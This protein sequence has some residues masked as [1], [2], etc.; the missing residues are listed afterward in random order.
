MRTVPADFLEPHFNSTKTP[1]QVVEVDFGASDYVYFTSHSTVPTPDGF[2]V[3]PKGVK[4]VSGTSQKID[5]SVGRSTIGNIKVDLLDISDAL[6]TILK[7]RDDAGRG[8]RHKRVRAYQGFENMTWAQ[9]STNLIQTQIITGLSEHKGNYVFSCS[10]IQRTARDKIFSKA[11]ARLS[12]SI[13]STQLLIPVLTTDGFEICW[14]GSSYTDAPDTYVGYGLIDDEVIRYTGTTVDGSLGLCFVADQRGALNTAPA[15][16]EVDPEDTSDRA[17]YFE[18]FVYLELPAPKLIYA[19]LTGVLYGDGEV[20]PSNWHLNISEDFVYAQ[21]YLDAGDDLWLSDE[22]EGFIL[23]F[24]GEK[25][26]DGKKFIEQQICLLISAFLPVYSTGELGFK[27]ATSVLHRAPYVFELNE[28]S[29]KEFS[30][31]TFDTKAVH[32]LLTVKWNY[33]FLRDELTRQRIINDDLS[34]A[35]YGSAPALELSF[36]GLHGSRHTSAAVEALFD[37]LRDRFAAPPITMTL[38]CMPYTN[39]LEVGDIVRVN[40][41]GTKDYFD[42]GKIDRAM[43]IQSVSVDWTSGDVSFNLFGSSRSAGLIAPS[44]P[45]NGTDPSSAI[46]PD[47]WYTANGTDL[48]TYAGVDITVVGDVGHITGG[49]GIVGGANMLAGT[50][51]YDGDLEL[52]TGVVLPFTKNV[53]L[54]VK[55]HLQINGEFNGTG[56]G[57]LAAAALGYVDAYEETNHINSSAVPTPQFLK[58]GP[59]GGG[60]YLFDSYPGFGADNGLTHVVPP[61]SVRVANDFVY[62][63]PLNLQGTG[64]ATG[65]NWV[66]VDFNPPLSYR[67]IAGGG[68]GKGGAGLLITSRG[69]SFGVSGK[70]VSNGADGSQGANFTVPE[71]TDARGV[72]TPEATVYG[73]TGGGG[74]CGAVIFN[75]DGIA[76]SVPEQSHVETIYGASPYSPATPATTPTGGWNND[77]DRY[78]YYVGYGISPPDLSGFAG[79]SR[80]VFVPPTA[81]AIE[82]TLIAK[83]LTE[84]EWEDVKNSTGNKAEDGA[85]AGATWGDNI[86]SQP[87][88]S[89]LLNDQQEWNDVQD[90][91][92]TR[93]ANNADVTAQSPQGAGWLT[94]NVVGDHNTVTNVNNDSYF[95]DDSMSADWSDFAASSEYEWNMSTTVKTHP[96][97]SPSTAFISM[98]YADNIIPKRFIY[99]ALVHNTDTIDRLVH[100]GILNA[101][102]VD[103]P[104]PSFKYFLDITVPAGGFLSF[105]NFY[106]F[107][108][109][110]VDAVGSWNF[111]MRSSDG[112]F[113]KMKYSGGYMYAEAR[114]K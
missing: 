42:G 78:S 50:Y 12:A 77:P 76:N 90:A 6:T 22:D 65:R 47:V 81:T 28:D 82:D 15:A 55:G 32:N 62:G 63:L 101:Y 20:L 9:L 91:G 14:H 37:R 39:F 95:D 74:A 61:V 25:E 16:H 8:I 3:I 19:L 26:Q 54:R 79:G 71:F 56:E 80:I 98:A 64:G 48:A 89:N 51:Y 84:V 31:T 83:P 94:N 105:N 52:D 24:A 73:G 86:A 57:G 1:V 46:I 36:R 111:F 108:W 30:P 40:L 53:Q 34:R 93:P 17:T 18:E 60:H 43:E 114:F 109:N 96:G 70:I 5:P 92:G 29:V 38:K 21:D 97:A 33:D 106:D 113:G 100:I 58:S 66:L 7:E 11:K 110:G 104:Q 75:I 13:D 45:Q 69:C 44:D 41:S 85:T 68:G 107:V 72:V 88:D 67:N 103:E 2:D 4:R 112:A 27:L 23:R 99:G 102:F 10:D 35:K 87:A 49:S 59:S